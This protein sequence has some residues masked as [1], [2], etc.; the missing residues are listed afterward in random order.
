MDCRQE[1]QRCTTGV[2]DLFNNNH[3]FDPAHSCNE[4]TD[5]PPEDE[6]LPRRGTRG[7]MLLRSNSPIFSTSCHLTPECPRTREFI[8][9]RMAPRTQDS[10]IL[11]DVRGSRRGRASRTLADEGRMPTCWCCSNAC[12]SAISSLVRV[13]AVY[14]KIGPLSSG[15]TNHEMYYSP[16]PPN[17]V[18]TP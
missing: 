3:W 14:R 12:P 2:I 18:L 7:V 1:Y 9:T 16:E 4:A 11:V 13:S 17:P 8:R 10:G 15:E 6:M 5:S